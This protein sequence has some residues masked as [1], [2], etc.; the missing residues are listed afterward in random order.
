M[1]GKLPNNWQITELSKV[2]V[3]S[4]GKKPNTL[5]N[6][7]Q[8]GFVPY[9]DI[10]A[11]EKGIIDDYADIQSSKLIDEGDVLVVWDGARCGLPGMGVVGA[12]GST[13]MVLKPVAI[14]PKYLLNFLKYFYDF[15]NSKPKGTGT[16]HVNSDLFWSL[17][18]P[19][20]PLNE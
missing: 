14:K 1:S 2:V 9:V 20:A 13:L 19:I 11:F 16:P 5:L 7:M 4:K 17:S 10:K 12:A 8:S 3:F 15:V 6:E 18:F